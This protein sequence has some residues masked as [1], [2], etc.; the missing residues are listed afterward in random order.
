MNIFKK[1][2]NSVKEFFDKLLWIVR[3]DW[4]KEEWFL[5]GSGCVLS[6]LLGGVIGFLSK[7]QLIG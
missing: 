7:S 1:A 4:Q 5:F 2:F 3:E 6:A